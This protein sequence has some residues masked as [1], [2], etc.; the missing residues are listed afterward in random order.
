MIRNPSGADTADL[1]ALLDGIAATVRPLCADGVVADYIPALG[2]VPR[3]RFGIALH[4]ASGEEVVAG[5]AEEPFS[6]QSISKVFNLAFALDDIGERLWRRVGREPSGMSFN[7]LVLLEQENGIPRNPLINAGA[8]VV[9]DAM[10]ARRVDWAYAF[11]A[12]MQALAETSEIGFDEE[13]FTS[14][15]AYGDLNRAIAW[16]LRAKG[17][18]RQHPD[19]STRAY[20]RHC[21]LAMSCRDLARAGR[22][23]IGPA[24]A[25]GMCEDPHRRRRIRAVMRTCGLYDAAGDFAYR[26]GLP[27]KSGVGGGVLAVSPGRYSVCVWS[28][29]LDAKGNSVAGV[30]AL[31]LLTDALE[32]SS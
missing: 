17:N 7:S 24:Q 27:A 18:L 6:I 4:L 16:F 8:I 10:L 3:D 25:P 15:D 1:Q 21:A 29:A 20:F 23:L 26:V 11:L 5:D 22:F 19:A 30:R 28:P 2:R 31:E 13:V 9:T 32:A 12:R 14:E